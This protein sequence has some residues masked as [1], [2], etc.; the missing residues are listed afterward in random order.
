MTQKARL[1]A[2]ICASFLATI[3]IFTGGFIAYFENIAPK[4][5]SIASDA[6]GT[7]SSYGGMNFGDFTSLAIVF[8]IVALLIYLII[9]S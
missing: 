9:K 1:I 6:A 8:A 7:L 2:L 4:S 3:L 5:R